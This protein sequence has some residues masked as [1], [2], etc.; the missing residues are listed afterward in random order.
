M[1]VVVSQ[2]P[3]HVKP[4]EPIFLEEFSLDFLESEYYVIFPGQ[5]VDEVIFIKSDSSLKKEAFPLILLGFVDLLDVPRNASMV[6][7]NIE[8][9]LPPK[10]TRLKDMGAVDKGEP[11]SVAFPI[12][13]E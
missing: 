6:F 9:G 1:T 13:T 10:S 11:F 4:L 3:A 7:K 12:M 8:I 2:A 5:D